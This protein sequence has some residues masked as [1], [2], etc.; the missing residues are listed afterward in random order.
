MERITNDLNNYNGVSL[1]AD[2]KTIATVQSQA[3]SGVWLAPNSKAET[4][5]KVSTGTN[6]G[7]GGVALLPDG[8]VVYTLAGSG[9]GELIKVDANGGNRKTL[10]ANSS[11]K[12]SA[13]SFC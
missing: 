9:T 1:S 3:N 7:L 12:W 11:L 4:A 6:E 8:G 2:G 5:F 13:R 10:T